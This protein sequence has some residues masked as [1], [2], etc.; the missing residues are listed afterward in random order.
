MF[1]DVLATD[2]FGNPVSSWAAAIGIVVAALL[3]GKALYWISSNVLRQ[4]TKRTKNR[5]DDIILDTVEKPIVF[6]FTV[7]GMWFGLNTLVLPE[8]VQRL[9][10]HGVQA[11][12]I[13]SAAWLL[14]RVLDALYQEYL[15]PITEQSATDLDDQVL[16]ILR[17][18]PRRG[19]GR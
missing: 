4:V 9:I 8:T 12:V 5:L 6:V 11:L 16:P 18:G 13:L 14:A 7:A 1:D 3:I 17:K 15:V 19:S 2:L 10:G